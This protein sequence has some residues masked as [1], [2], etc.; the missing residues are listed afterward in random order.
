[1]MRKTLKSGVWLVV[2][3]LFV[4]AGLLVIRDYR[5]FRQEAASSAV[6]KVAPN[7]P[8]TTLAGESM[9]LRALRGHP[10]WL[11]FF[12]TWCPPCKAETPDVEARY[13]ALRSR[14]LE[15]LGIDQEE[16]PQLVEPWIK[17]FGITFP[18]VIDE[19]PA[20]ASYD[21]FMLPT[22]VFIDAG[23]IVRAVHIGQMTPSQMDTDLK[24]ILN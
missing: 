19:G 15:V 10:V 9:Q 5:A 23:G 2:L 7:A 13:R 4:I 17:K 14:S 22:S 1:M 18:V 3:G 8:V 11:N 16:S 6:G 20:A 24:R 21:V 12:A